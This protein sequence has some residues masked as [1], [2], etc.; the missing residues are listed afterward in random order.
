MVIYVRTTLIEFMLFV[1]VSTDLE[2]YVLPIE[3]RSSRLTKL[4]LTQ[5]KQ[6]FTSTHLNIL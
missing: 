1:P 6:M 2:L 5:Q 3:S 4:N